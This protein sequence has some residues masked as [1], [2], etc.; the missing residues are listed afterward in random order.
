MGTITKRLAIKIEMPTVRALRINVLRD[1]KKDFVFAFI[2]SLARTL[3]AIIMRIQSVRGIESIK[4][5]R[6]VPVKEV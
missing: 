3:K 4:A 6:T 2:V 5:V 1:G